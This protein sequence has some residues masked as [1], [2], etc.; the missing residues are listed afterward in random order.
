MVKNL[1]SEASCGNCGIF[2]LSVTIFTFNLISK[3]AYFFKKRAAIFST[4]CILHVWAVQT[5]SSAHTHIPMFHEISLTK[6]KL[7]K[8]SQISLG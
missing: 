3:R 5:I 8:K 4:R 7:K 2:P 6:Q 1:L